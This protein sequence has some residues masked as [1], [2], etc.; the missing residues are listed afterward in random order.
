MSSKLA[1]E[2]MV[3]HCIFLSILVHLNNPVVTTFLLPHQHATKHY[4]SLICLFGAPNG[5]CLSITEC[6]HI[7]A[8]KE[9]WRYSSK[10][11]ALG[12]MLRTNQYLDKITSAC[13]DFENRKMLDK[14]CLPSTIDMLCVFNL[15]FA[16]R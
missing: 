14:P 16:Y 6:K 1:W 3:C 4:L 5:L 12:Q 15:F 9:P 2:Y 10:F 13:V 8:V 11:N 7:K